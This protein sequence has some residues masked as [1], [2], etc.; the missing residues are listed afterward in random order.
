MDSFSLDSIRAVFEADVRRGLGEA[1]SGL[2]RVVDAM[3]VG[4]TWGGLGS[5]LAK[6][7][8][9][10]A[11]AEAGA[12]GELAQIVAEANDLEALETSV[13]L[14]VES[15]CSSIETLLQLE[16]EG[17]RAEALQWGA[18]QVSESE[19]ML[20][21]V[22]KVL[23][24]GA[25]PSTTKA[26]KAKTKASGA[27]SQ[28]PL[29]AV[30]ERLAATRS[31][32]GSLE[33]V[34]H[35]YHT[36]AG[37]SGM[38]SLKALSECARF[39]ETLIGALRLLDG[40]RVVRL[41]RIDEIC[42][43][44]VGGTSA[45]ETV[46]AEDPFGFDAAPAA[47]SA[48]AG[49]DGGAKDEFSSLDFDAP[50]AAQK[51]EA[52]SRISALETALNFGGGSPV[53]K[54]APPAKAE[55]TDFGDDVFQA[56]SVVGAGAE[57]APAG[58]ESQVFEFGDGGSVN[59]EAPTQQGTLDG[60]D[61]ELIE[62]FLE[63]AR[64]CLGDLRRSF[65]R[66]AADPAD[67]VAW[68]D[69]ARQFHLLKGSAGTVGVVS[70]SQIASQLE[71]RAE[72]YGERKRR[73]SASDVAN[74]RADA[75]RMLASCKIEL[76]EQ[77]VAKSEGPAPGAELAK[78]F[79]EEAA[80]IVHAVEETL[81]GKADTTRVA[82]QE[83]TSLAALFHRLK[84]SAVLYGSEAI[85][86]TAAQ[87]HDV[88]DSGEWP[89][90]GVLLVR[91][92]VAELRKA[93]GM[94]E[95]KG[96]PA[97]VVGQ[98]SRGDEMLSVAVEAHDAVWEAFQMEVQE[99]VEQLDRIALELEG[100]EQPKRR[101]EDA[102]RCMHTLKGACNTV[103]LAPTGRMLHQVETWLE[104][105]LEAPALPSLG[106]IVGVMLE[107]LDGVKQN[108][109]EVAKGKV[110]DWMPRVRRRIDGGGRV[111]ASSIAAPSDRATGVATTAAS[112]TDN[113]SKTSEGS[114]SD[115][116]GRGTLRVTAERLDRLMDLIGEL[117]VHRSQLRSS[118]ASF[119][120][121]QK[122]LKKN[123]NRLFATIDRF[124][125]QY[126]FHGLAGRR[127]RT[128][129][130]TSS[131]RAPQSPNRAA[132][133]RDL[134]FSDIELDHY[135]D[136]NI[137]ARSL[138]E[139]DSDITA[140]QSQIDGE[141]ESFNAGA[142]G[143][144][145]LI[146]SLQ[147]EIT[148][149]RMVPVD[150]LF[151]QLRRPVRDAAARLGKDV[152]VRTSGEDVTLDKAIMDQLFAPL[153]H[154]VRNGVSHGIEAAADRTAA[155]KDA[156]GTIHLAARQEAG[157][158]VVEVTDDGRGL[159]FAALHRVGV[160]RG[161]IT[162]DT[163]QDD[164]RVRDLIFVSGLS[165]K[166]AA[167]EV[168]G[169][170][171]GCDVVRRA[172]ENLSGV[173]D[174]ISEPGRGTTFRITM[175]LTLAIY[176]ALLVKHAGLTF[177]LPI[178]FAERILDAEE[179]R[180]HESSGVR[181][182]RLDDQFLEVR[183]L[184]RMMG[185]PTADKPSQNCLVLRL[186]PD[187]IA[188]GIDEIIGQDE[189]V[190]KS[191]GDLLTGHQM[192]SGVTVDGEGNLILILE[193]SGLFHSSGRNNSGGSRG[194]RASDTEAREKGV[195]AASRRVRVLYADD[196]LSV[197]KAA[198]KFLAE[199]G[200][201][202]VLAVDGVD[203]LEKLRTQQIDMVFTDLEMPRMHGFELLR[204]MRYV[205]AFK[206][207]PVVVVTSRSGDKHRQQA[208]KLGC[209]GYLGKPFTPSTLREQILKFTGAKEGKNG[210]VVEREEVAR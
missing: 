34:E 123:R 90:D 60:V 27:S 114:V 131:A 176:R 97:E 205:P 59:S 133:S 189:I 120:R 11:D 102:F 95:T 48:A 201:D 146:S 23:D 80:E 204:E 150:Q 103:G 110:T 159:D 44:L 121:L 160:E 157:Q 2:R 6:R 181:R 198:E 24:G 126:E 115:A 71:D 3:S 122:A 199:V 22:R 50:S 101:L 107:A 73:A 175:P 46:R 185:L 9:D 143:F 203:A 166:R 20:G 155:G 68:L 96:T 79:Q 169:R 99:G 116:S 193:V 37:S 154:L 94:A 58:E 207:V 161:L 105:L 179:V 106:S 184:A 78:V 88:C 119:N 156:V 137:L 61:P 172:I 19:R 202:L 15:A 67:T 92:G 56:D 188:I 65:T 163:P 139:I 49:G 25:P 12:W 77:P 54:D 149:A 72:A 187:R 69:L 208:E 52:L 152:R 167:D 206:D 89:A 28:D 100:A 180:Y 70:L 190:V 104:S 113:G 140:I 136:I 192:F 209:D 125:E 165:T 1:R 151:L 144:G 38:V 18:Q 53:A 134:G 5:I 91:S 210:L 16:L 10:S 41:E 74:L 129:D 36:I 30:A 62:I 124:R 57:P 195:G 183:D 178:S 200:V 40:Q 158:I 117:V 153:L 35:C 47:D 135:E 42:S 55:A 66:V 173:V 191:L 64:Q 33:D 14:H 93:L 148:E 109:R 4:T 147:N 29:A 8:K 39:V 17:R 128:T 82:E 196:S 32:G 63:E 111:A 142:D 76:D 98:D 174:V 138:E 177:A 168:S 164:P 87:L 31:A 13:V 118:V 130:S 86:R 81:R 43:R 21:V 84:G 26:S 7:K 186:G 127:R 51:P 145:A 132:G 197:R 182:L 141:I 83:Q 194:D 170:G 85:G 108:L 171:V 45:A 112:R 162:A 75:R